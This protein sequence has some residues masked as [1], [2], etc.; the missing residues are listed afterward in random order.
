[1]AITKKF[2]KHLQKIRKE[3]GLSQEKLGEQAGLHRTYI[4]SVESG[5]RNPTITTLHSLAI[6]LGLTLSKMLEGV[7]GEESVD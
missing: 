6:S 2:G 5:T 3:K 1:M 7:E 4:S